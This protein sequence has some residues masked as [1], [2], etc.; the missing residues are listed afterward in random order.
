MSTRPAQSPSAKSSSPKSPSDV[1][2][3]EVANLTNQQFLERYAA[4]GRIGL[5][6][7]GGWLDRTIRRAQKGARADRAPS[8]FSHA[9][10]FEGKRLDG[11]EWVLESDL[12]YSQLKKIR[13]GVQENRLE[14]M[15]DED[16]YHNCAVLD[17]HLS[18]D[19]VQIVLAEA[20]NV[21]ARSAEYSLR[22]I[23]GTLLALNAGKALRD[24]E[25]LLARDNAMFCS[26][27]VQHCYAKIGIEFSPTVALKNTTPE[28]IAA[29]GYPHTRYMLVRHRLKRRIWDKAK[30]ARAT[31]TRPST[32]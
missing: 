31:K 17:F 24:R 6:G 9:F 12:E 23:A 25:N 7:G 28:D 29:S 3:V 4:P 11:K 2:I 19:Q 8:D 1:A 20:L 27:F 32:R 16:D 22:E 14:R 13:L 10:L 30:V 18:A 5:I 15:Y 26:A 21:M